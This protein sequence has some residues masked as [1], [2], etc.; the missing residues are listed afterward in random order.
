[1]VGMEGSGFIRR[2][3]L[4]SFQDVTSVLPSRGLSTRRLALVAEM[5][6][7]A[8]GRTQAH[9]P[10]PCTSRLVVAEGSRI[11]PTQ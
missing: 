5:P 3:L 7:V 9:S 1:M 10:A 6:A 11:G 4:A 2:S 8:L